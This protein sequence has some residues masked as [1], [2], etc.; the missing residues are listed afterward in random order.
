M[1]NTPGAVAKALLDAL[2][3]L[4]Y[5]KLV[6][7]AR[8]AFGIVVVGEQEQ[9]DV[10]LQLLRSTDAVPRDS[11]LAVWRFSQ[12]TNP[13]IALGKTELAIVIP[14]TEEQLKRARESFSGVPVLPVELEGF[15]SGEV[16]EQTV[17]LS[18]L[19]AD[20]VRTKLV[21]ELVDRLWERRLALGRT[22]PA[23]RDRIALRMIQEAVRNVKVLL[24]S[25]AGAAAG[26]NGAPTPATAQLVMHQALLIVSIAAVY[27]A[28]LE[29][30]RAIFSRVAPSMAPTLLL[31]GAE[32]AL[33]RLATAVGKEHRFG[34]LYG[35]AAAYVV[36]PTLSASS[37]LIAG[38]VARRVFRGRP[39]DQSRLA[40]AAART[41]ALGKRVAGGAGQGVG[42]ATGALST[43][44]RNHTDEPVLEPE[45]AATA[46]AL[47]EVKD[48]DQQPETDL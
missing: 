48:Q 6:S 37:T 45:N 3:T 29:D 20:Q 26:R 47:E 42:L 28:S 41:R 19:D 21:P 15:P 33:S 2:P 10:L 9:A 7:E 5:N 25:V 14:A 12:D 16:N 27:G 39:S 1:S 22:L 43:R 24:G 23:T 32:A 46:E 8:R 44:W 13:P 17:T 38:L 36:R 34:K 35:P 30:R 4:D 11:K 31:D 40:R 18:A